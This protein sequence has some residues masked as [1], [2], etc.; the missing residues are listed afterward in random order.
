MPSLP[1]YNLKKSKVGT[2]ELDDAVFAGEIHAHL[3]N[4]AVRTHIAKY[5]EY[6]TANSLTRSEVKA[7]RQKVYKQKGTGQARHGNSTAPIFVGGGKSHGPRPRRDSFKTN[8]KVMRAAM[9]SALS[10][11]QKEDRIFI[12]DSL[13]MDKFSTKAVAET[14]KTFGLQSALVVNEPGKDAEKRFSKSSRN[15]KGFKS[16]ATQGV[17]IFDL[18]KY[19]NLFL[20]QDA[21]KKLTERIKNV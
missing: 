14:M 1:L 2:V 4:Q 6:K 11:L 21:A 12:V 9:I 13:A 17:N 5:Y 10:Q 8:K 19:K 15:L 18:L 3:I 16:L 20:S 7:T